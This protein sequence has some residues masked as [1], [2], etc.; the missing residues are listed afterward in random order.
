MIK[1]KKIETIAIAII[2]NVKIIKK[3]ISF[4]ENLNNMLF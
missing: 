1:D 4:G 2:N 3:I